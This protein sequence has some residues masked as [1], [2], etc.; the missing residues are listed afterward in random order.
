M[1][2]HLHRHIT[3]VQTFPLHRPLA[4]HLSVGRTG[5]VV[6]KTV[7]ERVLHSADME[8]IGTT[9][10]LAIEERTVSTAHA[11]PRRVPVEKRTNCQASA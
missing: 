2:R 5:H 9:L 4:E 11:K 7:L 1:N 10:V 8:V 6:G 3:H